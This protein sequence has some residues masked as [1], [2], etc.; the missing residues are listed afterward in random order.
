MHLDSY[1]L[2]GKLHFATGNYTEALK[3]YDKAQLDTLEEKTLP[4]R[5]LKIM[6]EAFAIKALCIEKVS[7]N[8]SRAK[9]AEKEQQVIKCYETSGDLTLL[10]L[11][12][13]LFCDICDFSQLTRFIFHC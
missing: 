3:Y 9:M 1:I 8:R 13:I 5:S 2:L 6:A 7:G 4:P 10:Y 12:V 11:Q